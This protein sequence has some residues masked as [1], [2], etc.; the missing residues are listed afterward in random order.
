MSVG[1]MTNNISDGIEFLPFGIT[2][3]KEVFSYCVSKI[4]II[5]SVFQLYFVLACVEEWVWVSFSK[6]RT[7]VIY[8]PP[9][10]SCFGCDIIWAPHGVQ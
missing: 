2:L 8:L 5:S 1:L 9:D 6:W 3:A 7:Q 10:D 4:R